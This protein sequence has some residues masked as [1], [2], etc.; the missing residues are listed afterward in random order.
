MTYVLEVVD[1]EAGGEVRVLMGGK[2]DVGVAVHG[3][4]TAFLKEDGVDG[5]IALLKEAKAEA[6]PK[7]LKPLCPQAVELLSYLKRYDAITP[8][9]ASEELG[10]SHLPRRIKD[11]KEHGHVIVKTFEAGYHGKRYARYELVQKQ[12]PANA[13]GDDAIVG[14][15]TPNASPAAFQDYAERSEMAKAIGRSI[16]GVPPEFQEYPFE[17][18]ELGAP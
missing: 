8:L 2:G 17:G 3:P 1:T 9:K 7:P 12:E 16:S 4:R 14:F 5:L 11:L 15:E 6:W 10:I 18:E 13:W